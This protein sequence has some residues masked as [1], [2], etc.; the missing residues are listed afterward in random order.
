MSPLQNAILAPDETGTVNRGAIPIRDKG[1][2]RG[3]FRPPVW[4]GLAGSIL[5]GKA[6]SGQGCCSLGPKSRSILRGADQGGVNERGLGGLPG[7]FLGA[8]SQ[9]I[10]SSQALQM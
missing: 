5:Q 1:Q 8:V 9:A 2:E 10:Q 3:R 4:N 6:G 7:R